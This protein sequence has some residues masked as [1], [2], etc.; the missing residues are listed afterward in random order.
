M[1]VS[2]ADF[3]VELH[4]QHGGTI[5]TAGSPSLVRSL[6]AQGLLDELTLMKASQP[7]AVP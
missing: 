7:A 4:Q 6:I 3:I 1:K 5:G 2:V